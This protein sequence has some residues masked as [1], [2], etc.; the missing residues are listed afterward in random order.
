MS[1]V[2]AE[3]TSACALHMSAFD[4][5]RK[6]R[7][8]NPQHGDAR[9]LRRVRRYDPIGRPGPLDPREARR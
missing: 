8:L 4:P 9:E 6:L 1:A 5:K 3:R 7:R 2:G